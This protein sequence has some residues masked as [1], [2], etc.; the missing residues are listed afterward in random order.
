MAV[1]LLKERIQKIIEIIQTAEDEIANNVSA[2]VDPYSLLAR[3]VCFSVYQACEC[4]IHLEEELKPKTNEIP[5]KKIH[6]TRVLIAHFYHKVNIQIIF[7]IVKNDFPV[8]RAELLKL[9]D[10]L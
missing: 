9:A 8:L 2:D 7:D 1:Y 10:T 6:D 4:L 3:A 5:W